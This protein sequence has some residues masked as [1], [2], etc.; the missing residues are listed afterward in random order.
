M[1]CGPDDCASYCDQKMAR[2]KRSGSRKQPPNTLELQV[3]EC[4]ILHCGLHLSMYN[5]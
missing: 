1:K 2:T 3:N 5:S 4:M